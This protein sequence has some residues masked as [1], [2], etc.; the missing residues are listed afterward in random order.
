MNCRR[1]G[2]TGELIYK[3]GKPDPTRDTHVPYHGPWCVYPPVRCPVCYGSGVERDKPNLVAHTRVH[4]NEQGQPT[5]RSPIG[6]GPSKETIT[7]T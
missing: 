1:C 6:D 7:W 2:G 5:K 3:F 4:L